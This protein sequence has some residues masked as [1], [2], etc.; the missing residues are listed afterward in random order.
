MTNGVYT[1]LLVDDE[2]NILMALK[3]EL[4][5]WASE[6]N[7]DIA[8]AASAQQGLRFLETNAERTALIVSDLRMPETLGSDFLIEV[9]SL[10]PKIIT[11]LL[12]GYS[13][14]EEIVKAVSAGIFSFMLKPWDHPY[15]LAEMQKAMTHF[16]L[17][18]ENEET[19]DRMTEELKLAGELQKAFLRPNLPASAKIEFRGTYR[20]VDGIYCSG[21]Y[22]D[23]TLL[24]PDRYLILIGS[25]AGNSVRAALITAILKAII[26]PEYVH[27]LGN[28]AFA[29]ADFL[30]WL[31][32]RLHFAF[33]GSQEV[34][35]AFFAGVL[36]LKS[37]SL[38]YANA[39]STHP[40]IV[41]GLAVEEIPVSGSPLGGATQTLHSQNTLNLMRQD[42]LLFYTNG[43]SDH[44]KKTRLTEIMKKTP[45]GA[46][47]HQR[48]IDAVIAAGGTTKL[49]G[50]FTILTGLIL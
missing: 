19:L 30:D 8:T 2:P 22:Y 25:I 33:K 7:L 27:G 44:C 18:R 28:H 10:Y 11:L 39:G 13:D 5:E 26:Y 40:I 32:N 4:H 23:V 50:D 35:L 47:F 29:P 14:T 3:R 17:L 20:P 46:N 1:V 12:T 36:D 48:I 9:K 16:R 15:L 38:T 42:L 31:N 45:V 49:D 41:R 43:L 24:G 21:D 6:N 34:S 37:M